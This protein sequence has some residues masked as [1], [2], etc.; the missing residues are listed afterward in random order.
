MFR[1]RARACQFLDRRLFGES[2]DLKIGAMHAQQQPGLFID[3][4]LVVGHPGAVGGAYFAQGGVRLRHDVRDAERSADLD[5]LSARDDDFSA[6]GQGVERQQD[7]GCVVVDDDG[8][9]V[10]C[11]AGAVTREAWIQQLAKEPIHVDVALAPVSRFYIELE[12]GVAGGGIANVFQRGFRERGTSQVGVQDDT[13]RIDDRTQ[14][15]SQRLPN[16]ALDCAYDSGK[17]EV[18]GGYVEPRGCNL[19]AQTG[20][21]G[22]GRVGY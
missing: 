12:V 21:H 1:V 10:L 16:L 19:S 8:G 22:A 7:G 14:R 2:G 3:R 20:E 13:G 17:G 9:D 5:Q 11:G 15:V 18:N 4:P 6:L